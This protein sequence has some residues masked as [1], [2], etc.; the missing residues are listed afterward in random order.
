MV[1]LL[2]ERAKLESLQDK[3]MAGGFDDDEWGGEIFARKSRA[4]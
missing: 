2:N 3:E 1:G 4:V